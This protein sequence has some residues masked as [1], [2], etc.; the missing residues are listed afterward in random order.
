MV[1]VVLTI[2]GAVALGAGVGIIAGMLGVGGGT[3]LLP[4]FRLLFDMSAV[5]STAT[6]LFTIIPTSISGGI[7]HVRNKTCVPKLGVA[8]GLGGALTSWIGARLADVSPGWCVMLAAA[9]A[10][11]YSATTMF[12]KAMSAPKE[13]KSPAETG[14]QVG[15]GVSAEPMVGMSAGAEASADP[16]AGASVAAEVGAGAEAKTRA[17][18]STGPTAGASA[19]TEVS[20]D[21]AAGASAAA[22]VGTESNAASAATGSHSADSASSSATG[23]HSSDDA[24]SIPLATQIELNPKR[25]AGAALI[26]AVAGLASGYIGLGGG[27]LMIPMMMQLLHMPMKLTSGT[28][29]IAIMI[30]A[31]PAAIVQCSM[32]NVDLV[33]GIAVACGSIPGAI[34]GATLTKRVPERTL[35]FAFSF[36]LMFGAVMLVVKEVALML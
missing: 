15:A 16:A 32:G 20:A 34:Y 14:A 24:T 25:L 36:L 10:I 2:V 18:A 23:G 33:V 35:R 17:E 8:M 1:S 9:A 7:S 30:L 5:G 6:S 27:F 31:L 26:G 13:K 29:L 28:S 21:Q 4:A 3:V 12:R 22:G 19:R 11:G